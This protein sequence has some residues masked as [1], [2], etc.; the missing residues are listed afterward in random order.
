MAMMTRVTHETGNVSGGSQ[1]VKRSE[2]CDEKDMEARETKWR[3][4]EPGTLINYTC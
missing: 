3:T 2:L 1:V 4:M